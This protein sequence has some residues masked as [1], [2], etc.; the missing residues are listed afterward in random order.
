[1]LLAAGPLTKENVMAVQDLREWIA[2][3]DEIGEFTR[4]NGADAAPRDRRHRRP[5]PVGHGQSRPPV[6]PHQ[7]LPAG[8]R[9][10][11]NVITSVSR[12]ALSLGLPHR[13][14][15][16]V[17]SC[18][19]GARSSRTSSPNP[20]RWSTHGPVLENCSEGADVDADAS[21]PAPVW[22]SGDGGRYIGTG[23][24]VVMRDPDTGWVNSGTYR[25]QLH[26]E[27]TLGLYISPG[28]ARPPD[29]RQ[30][31]DAR[32]G[33]ARWRCPS[34]RTRCCC[35]SAASRSTTARTSS[36]WPARFAASRC[37]SSARR[38]RPAGARQRRDRV[39]G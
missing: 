32:P 12:V 33:R 19:P 39:R 27:Q 21:F 7:G 9:L 3:V 29:P 38:D 24:I 23:C 11:A 25:V 1:M 17:T 31:L 18:S 14:R 13:I 35:C 20:P 22:H 36:T 15:L 5:V 34:A 16:P 28:Q 2:R 4:V 10:V 30:V 8:H 37:R 6:R 26:D